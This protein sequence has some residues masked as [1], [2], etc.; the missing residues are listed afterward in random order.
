MLDAF[1]VTPAELPELGFDLPASQLGLVDPPEG[2]SMVIYDAQHATD[3]FG[4]GDTIQT[5]DGVPL[6]KV[7][8]PLTYYFSNDVDNVLP[9]GDDFESYADSYGDRDWILFLPKHVGQIDL[10]WRG[11]QHCGCEGEEDPDLMYP[12]EVW[13]LNL[14]QAEALDHIALLLWEEIL[15]PLHEYVTLQAYLDD[16]DTEFSEHRD[17]YHRL[18][19]KLFRPD[20]RLR[21]DSRDFA[22]DELTDREDLLHAWKWLRRSIAANKSTLDSLSTG[23]LSRRKAFL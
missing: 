22:L 8:F 18:E 23:F 19:H 17:E 16:G 5:A 9:Y 11:H 12:W 20:G 1:R 21:V 7:R 2:W 15:G 3:P 6:W 10:P 4:Y 13:P 14:D